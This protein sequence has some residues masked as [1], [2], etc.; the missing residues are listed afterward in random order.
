MIDAVM[1]GMMPRA[2]IVRRRRLPPLNRSKIPRN[3][4]APCWKM[5][6]RT[7]QLMPG[8]GMCAPMR[9]TARR[10]SVKRT[11]FRKSGMRNMFR[12]A[13]KNLLMCCCFPCYRFNLART[14]RAEAPP[15]QTPGKDY[16]L[17]RWGA[18]GCAPTKP[19]RRA[20]CAVPLQL[21]YDFETAAGFGAF[22]FRRLAEGVRV[23]CELHGQIAIAENRELVELAADEAVGAE[24]IRRDRFA[25]RKNVEVG[26]IEN[27]VAHAEQ[28]VKATLRAPAVQ[29]VLAAFKPTAARIAAA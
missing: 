25:C 6:S 7:R 22:V 27:R 23:N 16:L 24:K 19:L 17:P 5:D 28:I 20:R 8:V 3:E 26:E 13:S 15:L 2:K 14:G 9:Y 18:A 11:R 21:R 4:P 1:Y 12:N 10:A 29:W